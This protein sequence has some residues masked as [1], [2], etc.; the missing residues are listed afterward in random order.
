MTRIRHSISRATFGPALG[1]TLGLGLAPVIP[2][3]A[4]AQGMQMPPAPVSYVE[5]TP[6]PLP[7]INELPGRVSPTRVAEVRPRVGG[8]VEERVFTQGAHVAAGDVLYRLDKAPYAARLASAKATLQRAEAT[9]KNAQL[10]AGR[11][12]ELA[13]RNVSSRSSYDSAIATA[14]EAEADV[15]IAQASLDEAQLNLNYTDVTAPI[16]GVIGRA[17]VTEGALVTAQTDVM[18][19]I[20]QLDPLYVDFTQSSAQLR[21]LRKA[22]DAGQL[23]ATAPDAAMVT[24]TFDDGEEYSLPGKLLF[25][26]AT[27]DETTGQVTLRAE[28]PNPDNALLPGLY[29]RIRIEQAVRN[30]A[31]AIPQMSVLRDEQGNAQVYVIGADDTVAPRPVTLGTSFGNR[32]LVE[33]GLEAGEHVVVEGVQKLYP[34]AKV[35]PAEWQPPTPAQPASE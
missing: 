5:L 23:V 9:L 21:R 6:E 29:V 7:V 4:L 17:Q 20:Q 31:L 13:E 2:V 24:L 26:E 18:A 8:I 10:Q 34:G 22:M 3:A 1:L 35:V 19:T 11:Q 32:W 12:S 33:D 27:V 15:G 28:F 16:S 14:A 30:D 25:S